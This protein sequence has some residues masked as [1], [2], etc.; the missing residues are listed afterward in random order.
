MGNF[1]GS[2]NLMQLLGAKVVSMEVNGKPMNCVCIPVGW[3]DIHVTADKTTN[4]PNGAYL[5]IRGWGTSPKFRQAC[6][7]NN[8]DKEG[9]IAPSH[10]LSA[11]YTEDFQKAAVASAEARLRG[12]E[13]FMAENPSEEEI[14]KQASYAV[15]NKS[16]IGTLTPLERKEPEAYTGQAA[17]AQGVGEFVPPTV[18]ADGNV[19]PGADLPF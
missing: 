9:Y 16:R 8:T 17:P 7:A 10:Q 19:L 12:D 11:S 18:D 5:N 1:K 13:K 15:S 3:N 14:K 6:E 2:I 4:Q